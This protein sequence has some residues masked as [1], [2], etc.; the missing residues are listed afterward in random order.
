MIGVGH[1]TQDER[2]R[3]FDAILQG[4]AADTKDIVVRVSVVVLCGVA[5]W[6]ATEETIMLIWAFLIQRTR[7][8]IKA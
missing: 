3:Q 6:L 7:M 2:N 4:D 8:R 5:L 1:L